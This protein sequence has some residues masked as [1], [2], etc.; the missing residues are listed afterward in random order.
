[1]RR[2]SIGYFLSPSSVIRQLAA[3][4]ANVDGGL[5]CRLAD[6]DFERR[7]VLSG[8]TCSR[9]QQSAWQSSRRCCFWCTGG[10]GGGTRGGAGRTLSLGG[11]VVDRQ[12]AASLQERFDLLEPAFNP[13]RRCSSPSAAA[14][15]AQQSR[16]ATR[17]RR[18]RP[19]I[20]PGTLWLHSPAGAEGVDGGR[21]ATAIFHARVAARERRER[22]GCTEG[23]WAK[24]DAAVAGADRGLAAADRLCHARLEL[25]GVD[26]AAI[27]LPCYVGL[28][29]AAFGAAGAFGV[30]GAWWRPSGLLAVDVLLGAAAVTGRSGI[31]RSNR[32]PRSRLPGRCH[33][34]LLISPAAPRPPKRTPL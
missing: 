30:G 22:H 16:I 29:A 3:M 10:P 1:M 8:S 15:P 19:V 31:V 12:G 13:S 4:P 7:P 9:S 2:T 21:V 32:R 33:V 27:S 14:R 24:L 26:G 5:V 34:P 25:L 6:L 11:L 23:L 28:P 17:R 20:M 18:L